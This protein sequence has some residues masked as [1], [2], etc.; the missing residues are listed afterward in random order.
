MW[1]KLTNQKS[2]SATYQNASSSDT[3]AHD[4]SLDVADSSTN[5]IAGSSHTRT[6]DCSLNI[7][8]TEANIPPYTI[9]SRGSLR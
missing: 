1:I 6:H 2:N 8:N 7:T 5:Q 9:S 4:C 3:L